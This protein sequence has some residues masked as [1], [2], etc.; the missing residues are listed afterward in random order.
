MDVRLGLRSD[1][2]T[3]LAVL[4]AVTALVQEGKPISAEDDD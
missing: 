4:A 1:V 3:P 2:S